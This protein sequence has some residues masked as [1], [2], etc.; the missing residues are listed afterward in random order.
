MKE[1]LGFEMRAA[2]SDPDT[3]M[4]V[5]ST[6][7]SILAEVSHIYSPCECEQCIKVAVQ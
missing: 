3:A 7:S 5:L 2:L 4:S 6:V 1:D